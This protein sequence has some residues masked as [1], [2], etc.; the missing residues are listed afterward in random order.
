MSLA[1]QHMD[2]ARARARYWAHRTGAPYEEVE[3]D[4]YLG[5]VKAERRYEPDRGRTFRT[6]AWLWIGSEIMHAHRQREGYRKDRSFQAP[7]CV[8]LDDPA[9][10]VEV[11][12]HV[13]PADC[14]VERR[15][16][17]RMVDA[18][19]PRQR[20]AVRLH[21]QV[22]LTQHEIAPVLGVSQMTVSRT[23]TAACA[24]LREVVD[25]TRTG[26]I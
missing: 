21:Y 11:P 8:S 3:A 9:R 26:G 24:A 14:E 23:L 16:L 20:L 18:L 17:W 6:Y 2:L 10:P 12:G 25:P 15:D 19:K 22:G 13:A 4:A 5:L 7:K 1:E